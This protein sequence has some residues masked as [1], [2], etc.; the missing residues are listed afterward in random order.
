M[1]KAANVEF[2][3][4]ASRDLERARS[5]GAARV[6]GSYADLLDD[7]DIAMVFITTHNGLHADLAIEAMH[8]GKHVL[9]EKPLGVTEAEC[10]RMIRASEA[11]GCQL[12]EAFMYRFHPQIAALQEL[13][14]DGTLGE[15][16]EVHAAFHFDLT[17][18]D[19]VRLQPEWGGG[20]L[21]DVGCYCVNAARLFLGEDVTRVEGEC[22][23]DRPGGV[24]REGRAVLTFANG[25]TADL[26][27]GF[28]GPL[29]QGL[30]VR[31]SEGTATLNWPFAYRGEVQVLAWH[32]ASQGGRMELPDVDVYQLE[33]EAFA[34]AVLQGR[35]P[36]LPATDATHNAR[37]MDRIATHFAQA[38]R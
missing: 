38:G 28:N 14:R 26:S 15:V 29:R 4:A 31:G 27:F 19:D 17:R 2:I 1:R 37:I 23:L 22:T 5:L 21:L 34:E 33:I 36:P 30:E 9:C 7:P 8:R 13:V 18:S 11:T 12:M 24:D 35:E 16:R 3:G 6:H 32:S 20:A 10:A 25:A